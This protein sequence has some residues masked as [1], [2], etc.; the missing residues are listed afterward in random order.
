MKLLGFVG[1]TF[2]AA[3]QLLPPTNVEQLQKLA[4]S[5]AQ[6]VCQYLP[7]GKYVAFEVEPHP[8]QWLLEHAFA[9][10]LARCGV[11]ILEAADTVTR[12]KV[13]ITDIGVIYERLSEGH[14]R[15]TVRLGVVPTLRLSNRQLVALP[16][17]RAVHADTLSIAV[18]AAVE[19]PA[20]PFA[21]ARVPEHRSFWRDLLEPALALAAGGVILVLLFSLRTR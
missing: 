17:W 4:D 18:V 13:V 1:A 16:T 11:V 19:Q 7:G 14:V 12:L 6:A 21:T 20:Y 2:V 8:A 10:G 5:C 15:R 3:A 9:A